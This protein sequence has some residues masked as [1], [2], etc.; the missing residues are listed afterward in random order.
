MHS[1][2]FND[3]ATTEIYTLSLHDAL[4]ISNGNVQEVTKEVQGAD[5]SQVTF[6]YDGNNRVTTATTA[7]LGHQP[8]VTLT[9]TYDPVGNRRTLEDIVPAPDLT[10]YNYDLAGRL[11]TLTTPADHTFNLTYDPTGRLDTIQYPNGILSN[12]DYDTKGR[13]DHLVHPFTPAPNAVDVNYT[14]TPVGNIA[15][16]IDNVTTA[17]TR[18]FAYDTLQQLTTGGTSGAPEAY[19]Y[20]PVGNRTTSFLSTLHT[21]DDANR[22]TDDDQF[23]YTYDLNGNLATKTD[24]VTSGVTTY[25]WD[26]QNQ[27]IQIDVPGGT[28][29][30]YKYDGLGRRIEKDVNG[31]IS[32]YV[33]DGA[34]IALEYGGTNNFIARFTHG[35]QIDQPLAIQ[36]AGAFYFYHADHQGS[37]THLTKLDGS[38]ANEYRYDS[39]GNISFPIPE[40]VIQP[41][42]YTGREFDVESGLY[43]YRARYYDSQT[44]RFLSEDPI[45]FN[46]L[47]QNLY[48]YVF[49]DPVNFI[50]PEGNQPK[51]KSPLNPALDFALGIIKEFF[52]DPSTPPPN[53][54]DDINDLG[55]VLDIPGEVGQNEA[56]DF[57]TNTQGDKNINLDQGNKLGCTAGICPDRP[58]NRDPAP[59]NDP[60]PC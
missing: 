30:T 51:P 40:T 21:H 44:G 1:F 58:D 57:I 22:L 47:D 59:Q 38:L 37:I 55:D 29:T 9:S 54:L 13:L 6:T 50:D 39:F 36:K 18:T 20:D 17:Q 2:F 35:D 19:D 33:Y 7:P 60:D 25:T 3:T 46:G 10:E 53:P 31:N 45:R 32:R 27:L 15:S 28:S 4:P 34:D 42:T 24:K 49:N 5:E 43:Y 23:T 12:Y 26:A 14:Y 48:R 52:A 56:R 11:Q 16:I 8:A 41:F